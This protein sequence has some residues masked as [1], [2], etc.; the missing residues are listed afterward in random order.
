MDA[1]PW[2]LSYDQ[3]SRIC[4]GLD[5]WPRREAKRSFADAASAYGLE[6]SGEFVHPSSSISEEA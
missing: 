2:G 4:A 5:D 3:Q 6:Q 1:A